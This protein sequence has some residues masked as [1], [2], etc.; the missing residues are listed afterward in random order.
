MKSARTVSVGWAD[1]VVGDAEVDPAVTN[2]A[3]VRV[4]KANP[5]QKLAPG[6]LNDAGVPAIV[7]R[8]FV[9]TVN[10]VDVGTFFTDRFSAAFLL[11]NGFAAGLVLGR[12][13]ENTDA[14]GANCER[15]QC[16]D[17]GTRCASF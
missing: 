3:R 6:A 2:A 9:D 13:V 1:N 17:C 10:L 12:D 7:V 4:G 16:E 11:A 5:V 14:A 8:A 15:K